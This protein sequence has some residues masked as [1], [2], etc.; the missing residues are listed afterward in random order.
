MSHSDS[1]LVDPKKAPEAIR[2]HGI[3]ESG[4]L[5][6][7]PR[8]VPQAGRNVSCAR[9]LLRFRT[10]THGNTYRGASNRV[11]CELSQLGSTPSLAMRAQPAPPPLP[12]H[13]RGQTARGVLVP[14]CYEVLVHVHL[15]QELGSLALRTIRQQL[16]CHK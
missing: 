3:H 1:R 10:Q 9:N 4:E 2:F 16:H 6:R 15:D 5:P 7:T 13:G 12:S 11:R 14:R 8:E